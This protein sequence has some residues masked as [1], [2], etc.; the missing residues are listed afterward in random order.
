MRKARLLLVALV[1]ASMLVFAP[2]AAAD[3][4]ICS[5][6]LPPGTY[7]NV[8]VPAGAGCGLFS[9]TVLGN[10]KLLPGASFFGDSNTVHGNIEGDKAVSVDIVDFSFTPAASVVH[11]SIQ[12]KEG[13]VPT[14][15][16]PTGTAAFVRVCGTLL[17]GGNIQV[18]KFGP[19]GVVFVGGATFCPALLG[20]GNTLPKGSIKVEENGITVISF[21]SPFFGLGLEIG[22]NVV[23]QNL[24]VFKNT[25]PGT[26]VVAG[27]TVGESIQCKENS[28][29]FVGGPNTAPK[30]EDQCF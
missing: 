27:N 9:S 12:V 26:K 30:I 22:G 23:G 14:G 6:S 1:S 19:S 5:P 10:I 25:G 4:T 13:N 21:G 28:P 29:P 8:V 18:E 2:A 17:P 7:D 24:Q 20:G 3:D 16:P 11:G 15:P